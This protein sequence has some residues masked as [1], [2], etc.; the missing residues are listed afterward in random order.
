MLFITS[1]LIR[2][3][4]DCSIAL[5]LMLPIPKAFAFLN[6]LLIKSVIRFALSQVVLLMFQNDDF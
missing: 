5:F 2:Q 1:S 6:L 3:Q 4:Y